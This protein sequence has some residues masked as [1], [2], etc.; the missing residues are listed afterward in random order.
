[1]ALPLYI[2]SGGAFKRLDV[3]LDAPAAIAVVSAGTASSFTNNSANNIGVVSVT[4][5]P[6]GSQ[7]GDLVS[8][9]A[10][11]NTTGD[12]LVIVQ[13]GSGLGI[14]ISMPSGGGGFFGIDITSNNLGVSAYENG[15]RLSNNT[16][17]ANNAQ[18][19]SPDLVFRGAGWG[20]TG[21]AS[22]V[23]DFAIK[24]L[25]VQG[26]VASGS[27][28]FA[29]GL[30]G[31]T[32]STV[33]K[34]LSAGAWQASDGTGGV[35]AFGF[36]AD[37]TM[38]MYRVTND[39]HINAAS[40]LRYGIAGTNV[41]TMTSAVFIPNTD[42]SIDLGDTT[43]RRFKNLY[44]SGTSFTSTAQVIGGQSLDNAAW[45]QLVKKDAVI[46]ISAVNGYDSTSAESA[47]G[48]VIAGRG[49]GTSASP[50]VV[51]A[52]DHMGRFA[53]GGQVSTSVG[54]IGIG[55]YID[56]YATGTWSA[57][58]RP[59]QIQIFTCT[60][61]T[62][63]A[64]E[65]MR[66]LQDG[67]FQLPSFPSSAVGAAN[68][69]KI[70]YNDSTGKLQ[71]SLDGA[72]YVD[73]ATGSGG[74]MSIGGAVTGGTAGRVLYVATGPVL[75]QGGAGFAWD[76]STNTLTVSN[77]LT[78]GAATIATDKTYWTQTTSYA[79]TS[80]TGKYI[81]LQINS[82]LNQTGSAT[83]D[84]TV[85]DLNVT[86]T[87]AT[88]TNKRLIEGKVG[89]S[90]VF[91]VT[92][93]GVA[94]ILSLGRAGSVGSLIIGNDANT[95]FIQ[96]GQSGVS[97]QIQASLTSQGSFTA[98]NHVTLGNVSGASN[99]TSRGIT[100]IDR[101][102]TI[103]ENV[104]ADIR[105]LSILQTF[106]PTSGSTEWIGIGITATINQTGTATGDWTGLLI[107]LTLTA[108]TG[109]NQRFI[110][111][112]TG[113]SAKF[114]VTTGGA[115]DMS[116]NIDIGSS[117]PAVRSTTSNT[118]LQL[119]G[120]KSASD[121]GS[122]VITQG[123]VTRTAGKLLTVRNLNVDFASF[124]YHGGLEISPDPQDT[125]TPFLA[126]W[127]SAAHTNQTAST[128]VPDVLLTLTATR[129]WAT[130][131][132]SSQRAIKILPPTYAFNASSTISTAATLGVT[133]AP[134][135]GTN[136][137]ITN[138][139]AILIETATA[140][141]GLG[142][143][144]ATANNAVRIV[145]SNASGRAI[146]VT[147]TT[148]GTVPQI[149]L[150][151]SGTSSGAGMAISCGGSS[152]SSALNIT[153]DG[154]GT[155]VIATMT[156]SGSNP[157][158]FDAVVTGITA[159]STARSGTRIRGKDSDATDTVVYS[160]M[161][162][163]RGSGWTGSVAQNVEF[164]LQVRPV[165]AATPTGTIHLLYALGGGAFS[166][167]LTIS[168]TGTVG[169]TGQASDPSS[170]SAG[171]VWYQTTSDVLK[172]RDA[173]ATQT[174]AVLGL[175]Q[176]FTKQQAST[177]TA[178]TDATNISVNAL[179][180]N[181]FTVTLGGNRTLDNPSNLAAGQTF[182]FVITQ[183]GT[184]G[185]TLAYGS[186]YNFGIEGTPT[187]STGAGKIDVISCLVLSTSKISCTI[188]KGF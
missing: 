59:C 99:V 112:R 183:D 88:G 122:D 45:H 128:E 148:N 72:A 173:S 53:F 18:Q 79:P 96:I 146:L 144:H 166:S 139:H 174:V 77:L 70:N 178:L 36:I 82:T 52:A 160:P 116:G 117:Q 83:G 188:L 27:L 115:I 34:L 81:A 177:P 40:A 80:G 60:S 71:V 74:G 120:R 68:T 78:T 30:A 165:S 135:A 107:D 46:A 121:V 58:S 3:I 153:V 39:L 157:W 85:L 133:G 54:A 55:A 44:L 8:I 15:I 149:D 123:N 73:I 125:G 6:A 61:G 114:I 110:D 41:M 100:V 22:Q 1:M 4:K 106:A 134:I 118:S 23:I 38:G 175:A 75:A 56:G 136:A 161:F 124:Y 92:S 163:I 171:Q 13:N 5:S 176:S 90:S 69:A 10:G 104:A 51:V 164:A 20:T 33:A 109:I 21:G 142:I 94:Q 155:G 93:A 28:E 62:T 172:Y 37:P 169:I 49:R 186:A 102:V 127:T 31:A 141:H 130:G 145:I 168:S 65:K 187:L 29:F 26:T 129:T 57:T 16:A 150:N 119:T 137:T 126:K 17:A 87:A 35:K 95:N 101:G 14:D 64:T 181:V 76:D 111:F 86:E 140:G 19:A 113:G 103:T 162:T 159:L 7:S 132:I 184:G 180:G 32:A 2:T 98:N 9:T 67:G 66:I 42:N 48:T 151:R 11:A 147:E 156:N 131:A 105:G 91:A 182:M 63:T 24:A 47:F 158:A 143:L 167:A 154:T 179:N 25:P 170:P 185:R 84:Y 50:D 97:T 152:S 89:G 108:A 138:S 12:A 43:P